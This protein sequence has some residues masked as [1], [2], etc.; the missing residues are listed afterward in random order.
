MK[1]SQ[2]EAHRLKKRVAQ[3]ESERRNMRN[4]WAS[5]WRGG[6]INIER[7]A[8]GVESFAKIITARKLGHAVI[9]LP[10]GNGTNVLIY[11]DRL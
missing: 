9:L 7:L 2:R 8:F 10:E 6:W 5:E 3:L 11:A 4:A 1:I